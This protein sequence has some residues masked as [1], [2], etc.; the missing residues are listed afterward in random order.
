MKGR[1]RE[2][3]GRRE[4]RRNMYVSGLRDVASFHTIYQNKHVGSI[5]IATRAFTHAF[6][7]VYSAHVY[8]HL[9]F[10]HSL[11]QLETPAEPLRVVHLDGVARGEAIPLAAVAARRCAL[12]VSDGLPLLALRHPGA[13]EAFSLAMT[14]CRVVRRRPVTRVPEVVKKT[15]FQL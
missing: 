8:S 1:R 12:P 3:K 9:R 11:D 15:K 7:H 13:H 5:W 10:F 14:T 4:K 2:K 6:T